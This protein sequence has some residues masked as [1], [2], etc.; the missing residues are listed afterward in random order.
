[1][2]FK[3]QKRDLLCQLKRQL[4]PSFILQTNNVSKR[5]LVF[6]NKELELFYIFTTQ[7][8]MG[9]QCKIALHPLYFKK[10]YF[11]PKRFFAWKSGLGSDPIKKYFYF[12]NKEGKFIVFDEQRT[13]SAN[14]IPTRIY[15]VGIN[16]GKPYLLKNGKWGI[17]GDFQQRKGSQIKVQIDTS[18]REPDVSLKSFIKF[19]GRSIYNSLLKKLDSS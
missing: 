13:S 15:R 14:E 10:I 12:Q 4:P 2:F 18:D 3:K 6:K 9:F 19:L 5:Q 16:I 1:M 17:E 11:Y 7:N 8:W